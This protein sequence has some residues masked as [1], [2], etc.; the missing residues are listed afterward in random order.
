MIGIGIDAWLTAGW[1][2][3]RK[4]A[5]PYVMRV[6]CCVCPHPPDRHASPTHHTTDLSYPQLVAAFLPP[7]VDDPSL[8]LD[9]IVARSFGAFASPE[10]WCCGLGVACDPCAVLLG[11]SF[12]LDSKTPHSDPSSNHNKQVIDL[13]PLGLPPT[14]TTTD[15]NGSGSDGGSA[16]RVYVAELFHGPSLAFKDLGM[17]VRGGVCGRIYI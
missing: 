16:R 11:Q 3:D 2:E 8:P 5:R 13:A 7:F 12:G 14:L 4:E 10:V 17:Q 9:E 6:A 15:N 1:A